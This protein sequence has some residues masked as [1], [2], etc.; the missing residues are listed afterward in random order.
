MRTTLDRF[1]NSEGCA[2]AGHVSLSVSGNHTGAATEY[3]HVPAC[4]LTPASPNAKDQVVLVLQGDWRG[5]FCRVIRWARKEKNAVVTPIQEVPS[6]C[7]ESL[8]LPAVDISLA[9]P[10]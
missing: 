5:R 6:A 7:N 3:H 2:P 4:F 8:V 1:A 10:L 9:I